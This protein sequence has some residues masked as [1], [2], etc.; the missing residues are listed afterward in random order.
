VKLVTWACDSVQHYHQIADV[1]AT[2]DL[3]YTFEPTDVQELSKLTRAKYLPLAYDPSK[4]HPINSSKRC[5]IDIAFVGTLHSPGRRE[6]LRYVARELP[7]A[8]IEVWSDSRNWY[9]PLR[10]NDILFTASQRNL[11]LRRKTL[12]H[13]SVNQIYNDSRIC[14]N[15]TH[16]QSIEG[17]NPRTFEVLGSQGLLV[18]DKR[19]DSLEDFVCG[20]D[21][22]LYASRS[23]LIDKLSRYLS[24]EEGGFEI[25]ESGHSKVE[26]RHTY[27]HRALTI[28]NDLSRT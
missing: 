18:T 26:K 1:A 2:C 3:A 24:D 19:L 28:M 8:E 22:V 25:R 16:P 7:D 17:V 9:S 15:I 4:Y 6:L 14:L 20:R 23:N 27:A 13:A 21:Y 11:H 12:E 5:G 10:L